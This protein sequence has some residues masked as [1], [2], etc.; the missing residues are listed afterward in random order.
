MYKAFYLY[1]FGVLS[2]YSMAIQSLEHVFS[3]HTP[4]QMRIICKSLHEYS[5]IKSS[6]L[7]GPDKLMFEGF[8]K[9]LYNG[10]NILNES[11][12]N[13]VI[14]GWMPLNDN[15]YSEHKITRNDN[16][17]IIESQKIPLYFIFAKVTLDSKLIIDKIINNPSIDCDIELCFMKEHLDILAKESDTQLDI[18]PLKDDDNGRWYLILSNIINFKSSP[19]I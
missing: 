9:N 7:S 4:Y 6:N 3:R 11:N 16:E 15:T 19:N 12:S 5:I 13:R 1:F 18:S 2:A 10:F 17:P 8:A 14:F